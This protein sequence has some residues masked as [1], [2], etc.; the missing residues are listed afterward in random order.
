MSMSLVQRAVNIHGLSVAITAVDPKFTWGTHDGQ[1]FSTVLTAAYD[2]VVHW[3]PN[4]F[5]VPFGK[6][7]KQ[8]VL[9]LARL[10]RAF[11]EGSALELKATTVLT[12]LTLQKPFRNSKAKTHSHYLDRRLTSW[13][14]GA[15]MTYSLKARLFKIAASSLQVGQ[16]HPLNQT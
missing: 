8:F 4:L 2:K 3:R 15:F 1:S 7:G 6:T 16:H 14:N 5:L 9:E 12:I 13:L 11:A 10:Y